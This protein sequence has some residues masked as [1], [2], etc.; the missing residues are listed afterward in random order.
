[1]KEI[2]VE[3]KKGQKHIVSS[4]RLR[5]F[6][7]PDTTHTDP[8]IRAIITLHEADLLRNLNDGTA[9]GEIREKVEREVKKLF[10]ES[11]E[12]KKRNAVIIPPSTGMT[13]ALKQR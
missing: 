1:M 13:S 2:S 5:G 7:K 12:M 9:F 6:W 8:E 11:E 4:M 10:E 3:Q